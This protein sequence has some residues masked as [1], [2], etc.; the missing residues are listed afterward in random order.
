MIRVLL[1]GCPPSLAAGMERVA[2]VSVV[3]VIDNGTDPAQHSEAVDA[4]VAAVGREPDDLDRLRR[5]RE[6]LP[7]ARAIA[8]SSESAERLV[9]AAFV[10][11]AHGFLVEPASPG[12]VRQAVL[13][14][15][16]GG[17]FVDPRA[18]RGLVDL[19]LAGQRSHGPFGL[20]VQQLRVLERLPQGLTNREIAE[21]L[22]LSDHTVKS[23]V[24]E[25]LRKLDAADR[26]EATVIARRRGLL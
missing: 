4:A 7:R 13:I 16:R 21:Q 10:A 3:G 25:I 1:L 12:L 15:V 5:I 24:R 23:H 6:R 8:L 19:A 26:V 11:G 14:A 18:A 22:G 9:I 2:D 20:T 17:T